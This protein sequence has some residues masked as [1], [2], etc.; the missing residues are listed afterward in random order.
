MNLPAPVYSFPDGVTLWIYTGFSPRR[1]HRYVV[2]FIR[3]VSSFIKRTGAGAASQ[4]TIAGMI[5]SVKC[6]NNTGI[7]IHPIAVGD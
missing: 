1:H 5:S 6:L 4:S 2:V 3:L 7:R